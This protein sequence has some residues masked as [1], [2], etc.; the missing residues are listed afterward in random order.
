MGSTTSSSLWKRD[1]D[2]TGA[3]MA[4]PRLIIMRDAGRDDI[5][6]GTYILR[7]FAQ[8][9]L[10]LA[11]GRFRHGRVIDIPTGE[12]IY[13]GS[14]L[15]AKGATS[16]GRRLVRHATRSGEKEPH[17]IRPQMIEALRQAGLGCGSLLPGNGKKL[18]W[19]IDYLL[20]QSTVELRSVVAIQSTRRLEAR[21]ARWL[22]GDPG[23][24]IIKKGL[25]A[26]DNPGQTHLLGLRGGD[27]WWSALPEKL[28]KLLAS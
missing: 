17:H 18:F 26:S 22:E 10:A 8:E 28:R 9:A 2:R 14:A 5:Q 15:A 25:G 12:Y 7:I 1:G 27:D 20:D 23:T 11:F 16:L 21:I 6:S 3:G 4:L 24:F 13:V 19:N